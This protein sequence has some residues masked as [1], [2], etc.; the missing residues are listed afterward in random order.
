M[1]TQV[2]G[3][4]LQPD[5]NSDMGTAMSSYDRIWGVV[6]PGFKKVTDGR[7]GL[8]MVRQDIE[9]YLTIEQ[10][11]RARDYPG[12]ELHGR[13]RLKALGL[14]TGDTALIRPYRHGGFFRFLTGDIFTTW[15]PRPFRELAVT[16][17][18]S[19]R[20]VPTVEVYGACVKRVR[21]PFYRGWLVTRQLKEGQDLWTAMQNE[22]ARHAGVGALFQAVAAS[23]RDLHREGVYHRD[24]NLK[25]IL[26]R[27]EANGVKGYIIDFD[28]ATLFLGKV[29]ETM[30][31]R[32]LKRL[33]RSARKLDPKRHY[34]S[35]KDWE[36]FVDLYHGRNAEV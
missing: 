26:V 21:G 10:C 11:T 17:E 4:F 28:K 8:M 23:L 33:L 15:P 20:G 6:P 1:P 30:V 14:P 13:D 35:E 7:G 31:E 3:F 19:R 5:R 25:N 34:F 24:L 36:M 32:N 12:Q 18:I 22:F 2:T 16:E 29:P 9:G 27:R